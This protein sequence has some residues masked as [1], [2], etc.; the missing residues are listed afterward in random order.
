MSEQKVSFMQ[1]LDTWADAYV[2]SPLLYSEDENDTE[3]TE[4]SVQQVKRALRAKVLESYRNGQSAGP[5]RG[6]RDFQRAP[7]VQRVGQYR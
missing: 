7:E 3:V 1:E 6:G 2:I 4:E 5:R